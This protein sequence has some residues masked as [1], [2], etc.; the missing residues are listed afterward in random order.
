MTAWFEP[1]L[2]SALL[3]I[4]LAPGCARA[5][6]SPARPSFAA[7]PPAEPSDRPGQRLAELERSLADSEGEL[8]AALPFPPALPTPPAPATAMPAEEGVYASE[9]GDADAELEAADEPQAGAKA[10]APAAAPPVTSTAPG[11]GPPRVGRAQRDEPPCAVACRALDSM[12]RSAK[13][14]CAL[15]GDGSTSCVDARERVAAARDRV[16]GAGCGCAG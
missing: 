12:N 3:L 11:Q 4:L 7:P 16:A 2:F 15:A 8:L 13:R 9:S 10:E 6:S 14:I 1:R 5:I